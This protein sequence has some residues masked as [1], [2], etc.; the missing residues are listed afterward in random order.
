MERRELF[1]PWM[2]R[3]A[4]RAEAA[5]A[6]LR[7]ER[8]AAGDTRFTLYRGVHAGAREAVL[9]LH[10]YSSD[11]HVWVRC[12][13]HLARHY[14]VVIPDLA[15]HGDTGFDPATD[16]GMAAQADRVAA[17][18]DALGIARAHVVGNSMG[19]FV[20]GQL[21]LR[22][23]ER[24]VRLV[25]IAAAGVTSPQ[26]SELDRILESGR[27]PF[28]LDTAADFPRFYAMTM[29]RPPWLP[30]AIVRHL[31]RGYRD[32][33]D[34]LATIFEQF[35]QRDLLDERLADIRAPTLVV[36]GAHDRLLHVS[37]AERWAAGIPDAAL[38]VWDDLGHMPQLEAPGRTARE[39][40]RFLGAGRG[41]A[42]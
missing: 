37:G 10:G 29:K 23:P 34:A 27:N 30:G 16:H 36:W 17:L 24:V 9:L 2:Y 35:F 11:R 22:H 32:R 41:G 39:V 14:D 25:L 28:L 12:A 20:A 31:G 42:Q 40:R 21:A 26:Q 4:L 3:L 5:R 8:H 18:L 33:R 19:G 7:T 13:R 6:G 15:G 38:V 1:G